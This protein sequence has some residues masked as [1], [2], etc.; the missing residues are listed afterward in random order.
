MAEEAANRSAAVNSVAGIA[1]SLGVMPSM[2][3]SSAGKVNT[4]GFGK[5]YGETA[6]AVTNP[7]QALDQLRDKVNAG[8]VPN[9]GSG[10]IPTTQQ[11]MDGF[12]NASINANN[13]VAK[14]E[15]TKLDPSGVTYTAPEKNT[16]TGGG[17]GG[18]KAG[19]KSAGGGKESFVDNTIAELDFGIDNFDVGESGG[20]GGG[21]DYQGFV[22]SD[23]VNQAFAYTQ[24]L[25]EQLSGG[26]TSYSDRID[27]LINEIMNREKFS[28]DA[29]TDPLFQQMLASSMNSG[30]LAMEDTIGTAASLT[31]G[32]GNSYATRAG[33]SAYNQ[34]ISEAYE[35]LPDYYN[36]AMQAYEMEGNQML[37]KLGV[38]RDADDTEYSRLMDAY[39]INNDYANTMYDREYQQFWDDT[40]FRNEE[41]WNNK[42]FDYNEHRDNV[43][44]SKWQAEFDRG[45]YEDDRNFDYMVDRDAVSDA[46]WQA[47]FDLDY[48]DQMIGAL[49]QSTGVGLDSLTNAEFNEMAELYAAAG[50]R[51]PDYYIYDEKGNAVAGGDA[52]VLDYL[53]MIGKSNIDS[54]ALDR[55]LGGLQ[56]R[57]LKDPTQKMYAEAMQAY[58]EGGKRAFEEYCNTVS[59]YK[60]EDLV[61]HIDAYGKVTNLS[62]MTFTKVKDTKNGFGGID[63]NDTVK[64]QYGNLYFLDELPSDVAKVLT[65]IKE[66]ETFNFS[67][68]EKVK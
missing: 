64:D 47:R 17:G 9:S 19:G 23:I 31:G 65:D 8:Y 50:G 15:A 4:T 2:Q 30:K 7:N 62:A 39:N 55:Y 63:N 6:S 28:Y 22:Q 13:T 29:D 20:G 14:G 18:N 53:S 38:L 3:I 16:S 42:Y 5:K 66:G 37:N 48:M 24:S 51:D 12:A 41:Y 54:M 56:G 43:S 59:D 32:Y 21:F 33:N 40:N 1:G 34:Y 67:T 44:D 49:G 35:N 46:Q 68:W 60:I 52:A 26:R 10:I 57:L 61:D 27:A 45:V 11:K 25:R 58:A 36:L